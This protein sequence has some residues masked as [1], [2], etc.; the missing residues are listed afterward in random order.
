MT[1][2]NKERRL[3]YHTVRDEGMPMKGFFH[4]PPPHSL[5][6][7]LLLLRFPKELILDMKQEENLFFSEGWAHA[8]DEVRSKFL[9]KAAGMSL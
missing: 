7:P 2:E 8:G 1:G 6:L 9:P 3:L 5:L 4:S